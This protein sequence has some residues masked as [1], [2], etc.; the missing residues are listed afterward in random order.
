MAYRRHW[1]SLVE[2]GLRYLLRFPVLPH[3]RGRAVRGP[4]WD[5]QKVVVVRV[6]VVERPFDL[7][8]IAVLAFYPALAGGR[9]VHFES[10]FHQSEVRKEQLHVLEF[11][12]SQDDCFWQAIATRSSGF[13]SAA[14]QIFLVFEF[15]RTRDHWNSAGSSLAI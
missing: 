10:F 1:L 13:C 7:K 4:P 2:E 12:C 15:H 9:N 11:V 3:S 5:N 6:N 14:Y 8:T